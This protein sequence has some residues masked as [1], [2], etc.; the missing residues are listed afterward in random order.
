[1]SEPTP[2]SDLALPNWLYRRKIIFRSLTFCALCASAVVLS[3][4]LALFLNVVFKFALDPSVVQLMTTILYTA[5]FVGTSI[6]GSYVFGANSDY[7]NA[8][9]HALQLLQHAIEVKSNDIT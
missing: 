8:R 3:T 9:Q 1:M 6:I 2:P 4:C 5:A 7:A